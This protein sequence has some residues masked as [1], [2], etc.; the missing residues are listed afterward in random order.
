MQRRHVSIEAVLG[1]VRIAACILALLPGHAVAQTGSVLT[2]AV[3]TIAQEVGRD[4]LID[5]QAVL[6][7]RVGS[8]RSTI[9]CYVV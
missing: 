8:F 7:R 9:C 5:R 3:L 6:S 4:Q 2:G 1:S